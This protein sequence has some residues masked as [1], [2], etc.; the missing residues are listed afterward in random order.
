MLEFKK[1]FL[2]LSILSFTAIIIFTLSLIALSGDVDGDLLFNLSLFS[3]ASLLILF[4]AS[5]LVSNNINRNLLPKSPYTLEFFVFLMLFF[6]FFDLSFLAFLC[7]TLTSVFS[8]LWSL[9]VYETD[10]KYNLNLSK[11]YLPLVL[12]SNLFLILFF[13]VSYMTQTLQLTFFFISFIIRF[14]LVTKCI[15]EIIE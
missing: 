1:L 13:M 5:F 8:I 11:I 10:I 6:S 2:S 9:A 7:L 12:F 15:D 14:I 3:I 4:F